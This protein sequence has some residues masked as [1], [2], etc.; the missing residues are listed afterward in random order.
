MNIKGEY[1]DVI[2]RNGRVI[3]NFGWRS[4]KIV[5]DFGRFLAALMKKDFE[6]QE[7]VGIEYIAVG[8]GS[9][10]EDEFKGRIRKFFGD[11]IIE[12]EGYW[13]WAKPI[14][15]INYTNLPDGEEISNAVRIELG[16]EENEPLEKTFEF[17]EFSLV[18]VGKKVDA[19]PDLDRLFLIN[20]VSHGPI[21]KDEDMTLSRTIN[22]TFPIES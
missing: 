15:E 5:A 14:D 17:R 16:F 22:L 4:N 2:L 8:S 1:K 18:G 3:K 21:T 6:F 12:N 13:V 20:Y 7:P 19:T 9:A 10:D 11:D